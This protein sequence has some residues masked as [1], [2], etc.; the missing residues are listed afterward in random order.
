MRKSLLLTALLGFACIANAQRAYYRYWFDNDTG[1][2]AQ[3]EVVG[4]KELALDVGGLSSGMHNIHLQVRNAAGKWSPVYSRYFFKSEATTAR[5]WFDNDMTM[6]HENAPTNGLV[7]LDITHLPIGLHAVHYQT[8]DGQGQPSAV[9]TRYFMVNQLQRSALSALISI[10]NEEPTIYELSDED[11]IIDVSDLS[12]GMHELHAVLIDA[13]GLRLAEETVAFEVKQPMV[14]ITLKASIE[15][16]SNEKDLDFSGVI[17]LRAYTATSFHRL[18]G[19]VQMSRAEDVPAGEGLLLAGEPGTYEV[20][21][22]KSY[23]Y[24]SNLLVGTTEATVLAQTADG[25]DNYILSSRDGELGFFLAE[26]GSTLTAGKAY[27]RIPSRQLT[28]AR[29]LRIMF[30][31]NPDA[32]ASPLGNTEEVTIYYNVSGQRIPAPRRGLNIIRMSDGTTK[33]VL[34]K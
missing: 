3:G 19:N 28:D 26:D 24:Y 12:I 7:E 27:L 29:R 23:T 25:C 15:T 5:Y 13:N 8:L 14:S 11:I 2:M 21:V 22:R 10:D 18:T 32:I 31:D 33:K 6:F 30:D 17:G 9:R 34:L 4:E 20:P 1:T 16:F